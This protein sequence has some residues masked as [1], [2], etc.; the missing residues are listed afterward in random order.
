MRI[1][2]CI[3]LGALSLTACKGDDEVVDSD[4]GEEVVDDGQSPT[5]SDPS[6][7]CLEHP[8][9]EGTVDL[10]NFQVKFD[11]PQGTED[12]PRNLFSEEDVDDQHHI[13][14]LRDGNMVDQAGVVAC[15]PE[16]GTCT[17]SFPGASYGL[18]CSSATDWRFRFVIKDYDGNEGTIEVQGGKG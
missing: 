4:T 9:G 1:H 5:L 8:D 14:W 15:D 6:A 13:E 3:L 10:W 11:D 7:L 18:T 17:G 16:G 12:V 2:L